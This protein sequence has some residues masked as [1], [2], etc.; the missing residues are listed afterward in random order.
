MA[1]LPRGTVT[2]LF[3][4][5]EGSTRLLKQLGERY[6]QVLADHRRFLRAAF[7][8]HGGQEIDTQGDAFFVAFQRAKD[9]VAAAATAQRAHAVHA[10]PDGSEVRVRM[11][12]HTGEPAVS[13]EGYLGLGVHRAARI[14][15]AGHGGQVLLS[16][17]TH[18]VL[19][20]DELPGV[21]L[22]DLGRHQLKDL[23]RP[24]RIYQLVLP[25]LPD[26]FPPLKALESQPDEATPFEGREGELAA[27]A[28]AAVAPRPW[29]RT[30]IGVLGI[31]GVLV[32]AVGLGAALLFTGGSE[33]LSRIDTDSA[34][35]IDANSNEIKKQ[36]AVGSGPGP[37]AAG[38]DAVWVAAVDGTVSRIDPKANLVTQTI[39]L[40]GTPSGI[41]FGSD[42]VWVV[43]SEERS[44]RRISPSAAQP[45]APLQVGNGPSGVAVGHGAV[46]VTNRLDDTVSKVPTGRGPT[47]VLRA[48]LTPSGVAVSNDAVWVTNEAAGTV[49]RLDPTT[50]ALQAISVGNGPTGIAVGEGAVWVANSLD[51]T[52]SRIDLASNTV[53]ATIAV[54]TG[55]SALATGAGSIWVTNRFSGTVSRI[56]AKSNRVVDTIRVGESPG[57]I[58]F[59]EAGAWVSARGPLTNHRGGVLRLLAGA[60]TIDSVDPAAAYTVY[61]WDIVTMTNDGL[62]T[63]KR[64]AGSEGGQLVP[65]LA[66]SVPRASNGGKT[67]TF[68]LRSGIRYSNGREVR[69]SDLRR[70]LERFFEVDRVPGYYTSI[71]GARACLQKRKECDLGQGVVANDRA[72]TVTFNLAVADPEFLYQLAVPFAAAVPAGTPSRVAPT[73]SLVPATGPYMISRFIPKRHVVLVRNPRFREWSRA[74]QPEGFPDRIV[75]DLTKTVGA[76]IT[77]IQR[78]KADLMS[79]VLPPDR[80]GE[81]T[82]RYAEQ[83]H[84]NSRPQ[85]FFMFLNTRVPPFDQVDVRRALNFAVDRDKFIRLFLGPLQLQPTCQILPPNFPGYRPYCPYTRNASKNKRGTWTAPDLVQAKRL[86]E[87]SGTRGAKI[88][89]WGFRD[90]TLGND[91]KVAHYLASVLRRLGYR[92]SVR[93]VPSGLA[94]YFNTVNDSRNR[95][96]IGSYGW[97]ADYPAASSF[98]NALLSCQAFHPGTS[99]QTNVAEFCD[100]RIDAKINRALKLQATDQ[101]A[102]NALWAEIDRDLTDQ[103][104]VV[105]TSTAKILGFVSRRVGNYQYNPQWGVLL[106]QLWVR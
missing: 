18:A 78:N 92:T 54:G 55:P 85:S 71:V 86:I 100:S 89:V 39:S 56:E 6:G 17:A 53:T 90:P 8:E 66:T 77:A 5:I 14:C 84:V 43:S 88:T 22:R 51:A 44:V 76:Q 35:L 99:Q 27:A 42:A 96:Q 75:F 9:A 105:P 93:I 101:P 13:E 81:L 49:S 80:L 103:A 12:M 1:E 102:A 59:T 79:G 33:T 45:G 30:R 10:W 97:I 72:R 58:V 41:A 3:T 69:A 95:A 87:R 19:E 16:Q 47:T 28:Q 7:D 61:A 74:A 68:L 15:A 52:V 40:D 83:L 63:F 32:A 24:E 106:G 67:Y 34:G 21:E 46:W 11:G 94:S 20:D 65:D 36:V 38:A 48:G 29:Y 62:L 50:G 60:D 70:G 64:V 4:D 91:V 31:S 57:G 2:F 73:D 23:D 82:T 98:I 25:D 37:V 104:P 26:R